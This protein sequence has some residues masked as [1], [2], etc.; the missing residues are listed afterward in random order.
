MIPDT[1]RPARYHLK[2]P[3]PNP[4]LRSNCDVK[5]KGRATARPFL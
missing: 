2:H 5:E 1:P 4:Q 3:D